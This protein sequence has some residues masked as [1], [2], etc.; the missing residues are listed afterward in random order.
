MQQKYLTSW[1]LL[2]LLNG[3]NGFL[4]L[5]YGGNEE[6]YSFI[7]SYTQDLEDLEDVT[8]SVPRLVM[9]CRLPLVFLVSNLPSSCVGDDDLIPPF[10]PP[11][12]PRIKEWR[13]R[14]YGS[15]PHRMGL[16]MHFIN[17]CSKI[18]GGMNVV[19]IGYLY[20]QS[21][22]CWRSSRQHPPFSKQPEVEVW[23]GWLILENPKPKQ[24]S[25]S[26]HVGQML[27]FLVF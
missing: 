8:C 14:V 23:Q 27:F 4:Q 17:C 9:F 15:F 1:K 18:N 3:G 22:S 20:F 12:H 24:T 21:V 2:A 25:S 11:G 13:M 7:L 10:F 26:F 16:N 19:V 5:F 6:L